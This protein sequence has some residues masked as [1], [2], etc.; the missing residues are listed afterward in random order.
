M[1]TITQAFVLGAGLGTR[2]RPLT[3]DLP[4]PLVPIFQKPLITFALDHLID[5]GIESFVVNTH[6]LPEQFANAFADGIYRDRPVRLVHEPEL[7][8]TGGG[9]KNIEPYLESAPFIVYSG[10]VLTDIDLQPFIDEHFRGGNDV[11]LGLRQTGL[12]QDVALDDGRVLDIGNKYG[13]PGNYD[14]ANVSVWSPK[15]FERIPARTKISFIPIVT[16]WIGEDGKI[17]GVILNENRW[18]NIGSRAQYLEV[19]R[20]IADGWRPPYVITPEWPI[21][22]AKS[23]IVAAS[24]QLSGFF[25]IGTDCS[26]GDD[27]SIE[28][29]IL[30]P[31]AEIASKSRLHSCIV[32]ANRKVS[33]IHR[34]IDI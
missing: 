30:W 26:V 7:L 16:K 6:R 8:G 3:D 34:N 15:I 24:A 28:D 27:A 17:G 19:H 4:K 32:R 21:R 14:F 18:F 1:A 13:H 31:H 9:I 20:V 11:T 33:G 22:V 25:S 23:V 10:D 5:I 2:L 12:G 29:T